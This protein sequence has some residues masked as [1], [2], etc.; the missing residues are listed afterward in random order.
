M[1][2]PQSGSLILQTHHITTYSYRF[3]DTTINVV[4]TKNPPFVFREKL[5]E[6]VVAYYCVFLK[7]QS[8]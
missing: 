1:C 6:D 5:E 4:Q 7:R 8:G 2:Q 3:L